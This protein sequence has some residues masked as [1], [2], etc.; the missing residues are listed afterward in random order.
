MPPR[1][2]AAD[3]VTRWGADQRFVWVDGRLVRKFQRVEKESATGDDWAEP[4]VF[5]D[6]APFP[7]RLFEVER[8]VGEA[9][10]FHQIDFV[11]PAARLGMTVDVGRAVVLGRGVGGDGPSGGAD[12]ERDFAERFFVDS[13]ATGRVI[14]FVLFVII[15]VLFVIVPFFCWLFGIGGLIA[16]GRA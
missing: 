6:P 16:V 5:F 7:Q 3:V 11:A 4:G 2:S 1:L 9:R 15:L 10:R 13:L 14:I 12:V 8:V